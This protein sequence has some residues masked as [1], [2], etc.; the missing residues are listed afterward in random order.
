[1]M[2][3]YST[4]IKTDSFWWY[5][6]NMSKPGPWR[7]QTLFGLS[8]EN[9]T[10]PRIRPERAWWVRADFGPG[11]PDGL[12]VGLGPAQTQWDVGL[13]HA[14]S[15]R[16]KLGRDQRCRQLYMPVRALPRDPHFKGTFFEG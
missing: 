6:L 9:G 8:W 7:V 13:T 12:R 2:D 11:Q 5:A 10:D 1:M 14:R 15:T 16:S 3:C 4:D